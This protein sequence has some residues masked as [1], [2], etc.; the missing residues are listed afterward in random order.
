[1]PRLVD[2]DKQAITMPELTKAQLQTLRERLTRREAVLQA[3]VREARAERAERPSAQGPNVEDAVEGGEERFRHG[4][5]H[6]ELQRDQEE[7]RAIDDARERMDAGRYGACVDCG[8]DIPFARL[9]VQPFAQRCVDCQQ[10]WE[11]AHPTTPAFT[12]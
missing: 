7:L 8:R 10:K 4:I 6:A 11:R 9:E 2:C 12:V 3:E 1:L 5:E